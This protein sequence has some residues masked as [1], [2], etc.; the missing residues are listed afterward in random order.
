MRTDDLKLSR[1]E[2]LLGAAACLAPVPCAFDALAQ[3]PVT[4]PAEIAR[5]KGIVLGANVGPFEMKDSQTVLAR[6]SNVDPFKMRDSQGWTI[7]SKY[8]RGVASQATLDLALQRPTRTQPLNFHFTDILAKFAR[9]REFDFRIRPMLWWA[10]VPAWF[11][12][13]DNATAKEEW[14]SYVRTC[15]SR[16]RGQA[17]SIEMPFE[18]ID[19][20]GFGLRKDAYYIRMFGEQA[21]DL[22]YNTA[23]EADPSA[24]LVYSEHALEYAAPKN[25]R[26]RLAV[27]R[28]LERL[29]KRKVPIDTLG[30]EGHLWTGQLFNEGRLRAFLAEVAAMG[31][32]IHITELD[33]ADFNSP[34]QRRDLDVAAEYARFLRVVLDEPKVTRIYTHGISDQYSWIN[35]TKFY[36]EFGGRRADGSPQRPLPFDSDYRPKPAFDAIT[37][38]LTNAP[39]RG[40]VKSSKNS[41]T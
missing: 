38:A 29:L 39:P 3:V 2:L 37:E 6:D 15:V 5:I 20:D 22:F 33:C 30:I 34:D 10:R 26:R 13:L 21:L 18:A 19:E 40:P 7:L 9:A 12:G 1:R 23:R 35:R 28:L 41:T 4:S 36:A 16:Y 24:R 17:T 25:D 32:E 8:Y 14:L 31:L 11:V 27:L